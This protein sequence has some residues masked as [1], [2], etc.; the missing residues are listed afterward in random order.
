MKQLIIIYLLAIISFN[1]SAYGPTGHRVIASVAQDELKPGAKKQIEKILGKNGLIYF[2]T[3]ADEVR[4][5]PEYKYT[6]GWHY[7]NLQPGMSA[8]ALTQLWNNPTAEGEHLFYAIQELKNKLMKN[9]QDTVALKFLIH[10]MGDLHQPMHLGRLDDLGGNKVP[11]TWFGDKI[12]IHSL[13]D[14]YLIDHHQMSYTE[15]THYLEDTY[16]ADKSKY[17]QYTYPQII[18]KSYLITGRIYGY[19]TEDRNNYKYFRHFSND[20]NTMLYLGGIQ[21]SKILNEIY[22]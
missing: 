19:D 17:A 5:L 21:L 4:D 7:Q 15:L 6:S 12:N 3:W 20:L 11:Y 18:Q 14:S 9:K 2:S 8:E 10:F 22:G 13:W 16:S 1:L